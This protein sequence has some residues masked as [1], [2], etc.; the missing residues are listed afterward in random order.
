MSDN[1]AIC[2]IKRFLQK[3]IGKNKLGAASFM[4]PKSGTGSGFCQNRFFAPEKS[5]SREKMNHFRN[6]RNISCFDW[7]FCRFTIVNYR[8]NIGRKRKKC[9]AASALFRAGRS[10]RF[11]N[12]PKNAKKKLAKSH[13]SK[14]V[15]CCIIMS[16]NLAVLSFGQRLVSYAERG[17]ALAKMGTGQKVNYQKEMR[18]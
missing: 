16:I 13:L 2:I 7:L 1:F 9:A 11:G 10:A 6:F 18:K 4:P 15:G 12:P 17:K 8:K 5:K 3:C 14:K